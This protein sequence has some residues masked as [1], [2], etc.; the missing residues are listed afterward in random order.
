MTE[1]PNQA[2]TLEEADRYYVEHVQLDD[3]T[4]G[5]PHRTLQDSINK[6]AR[7]SGDW[8]EWCRT[9]PARVAYI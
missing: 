7:Q 9:Q 1:E 5:S 8:S 6:G 3:V 2:P 4:I